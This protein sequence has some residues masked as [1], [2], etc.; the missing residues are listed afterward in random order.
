MSP[1]TIAVIAYSV[2]G[3]VGAFRRIFRQCAHDDFA[4]LDG[5]GF[6]MS[7]FV[8]LCLG[9]CA[10]VF[11]PPYALVTA[12]FTGRANYDQMARVLGGESGDARHLRRLQAA[13]DRKREIERLERE[14]GIE[15][16]A[17]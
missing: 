13:T 6:A 17:A 12:A 4:P 14:L 7:L 5:E 16:E 8:A 1:I 15:S 3:F 9:L 10:A 11:Y 2:I